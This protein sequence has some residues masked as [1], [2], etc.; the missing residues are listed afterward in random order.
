[1]AF[2]HMDKAVIHQQAAKFEAANPVPKEGWFSKLLTALGMLFGGSH[3]QES[4]N[5][6]SDEFEDIPEGNPL[7]LHYMVDPYNFDP[8]CASNHNGTWEI[9]R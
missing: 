3:V 4:N 1:M 7:N 5:T 9:G 6:L 2:E 8:N